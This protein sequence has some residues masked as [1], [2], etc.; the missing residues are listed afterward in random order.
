MKNIS[1]S[2]TQN[3]IRRHKRIR[4]KVKGTPE[5][6]RLAVYKS[7]RHVHVQ[8]IDDVAGVTLAAVSSKSLGKGTVMEKAGEVG[9]QIAELAKKAGI[10]KAVFDRGGF[11]YTGKIKA[12]AEG[13]RE[14]G[15]AF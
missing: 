7:N 10:K 4:S 5:A 15:L 8:L 14:G 9:R 1:S 3:R 2:K 6:P 11:G 12:V 13:A